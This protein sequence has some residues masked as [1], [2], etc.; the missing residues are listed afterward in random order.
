METQSKAFTEIYLEFYR[1]L[2]ITNQEIL[3][4]PWMEMENTEME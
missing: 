1:T 4:H 3:L 2:F